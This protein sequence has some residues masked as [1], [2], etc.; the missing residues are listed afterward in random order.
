MNKQRIFDWSGMNIHGY[1][2]RGYINA[3]PNWYHRDELSAGNFIW[4]VAY[5][6]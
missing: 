4:R 2:T 6:E 5:V 1:D 3:R